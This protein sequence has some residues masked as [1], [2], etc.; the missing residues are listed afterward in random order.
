MTRYEEGLFVVE[1]AYSHAVH[2]CSMATAI[3]PHM[4]YGL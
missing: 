4:L 2:S 1:H 3:Y